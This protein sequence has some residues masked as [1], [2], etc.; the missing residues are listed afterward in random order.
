MRRSMAA[1]AT[2][3]AV[4]A[5]LAG[6]C[7]GSSG[8]TT[9]GPAGPVSS[10][11]RASSSVAFSLLPVFGAEPV[12]MPTSIGV[13]AWT[14]Y[15]FP[16]GHAL[17]RVMTTQH[18]AVASISPTSDEQSVFGWSADAVAWDGVEAGSFGIDDLARAGDDVVLY[19]RDVAVRYAW[20]GSGWD[21]S[22]ELEV[23][24]PVL[25]LAFGT[26][27]AVAT[28]SSADGVR[29]AHSS[30]G[31]TFEEVDGP[32]GRDVKGDH[33]GWSYQGW[34][35]RG[36]QVLATP[37]GFVAMTATDRMDWGHNSLCEP[38]TW[39]SPDGTSW[40]LRTP[41][42]RFGAGVVVD[43]V[44]EREG[45]FV[46]VGHVGDTYDGGAWSA[47]TSGDA[48]TWEPI[49]ADLT[50]IQA[51]SVSSGPLGW[52]ITGASWDGEGV[53]DLMWTSPDGLTWDGPHVLP[54]GFAS[55]WL[56]PELT[57]GTDAVFGLGARDLMPV[58]ARVVG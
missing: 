26:A 43:R 14:Q 36:A 25:S 13:L 31:V 2:V 52:I 20:N 48:I 5:G 18:G 34:G 41:E 1:V 4:S 22:A 19:G 37:S 44:A 8:P 11:S 17:W 51:L 57:I 35:P 47:W 50:G 24:G 29:F 33:C 21:R 7:T 40:T 28:Y 3:A 9:Y 12:W 38:L 30:D 54:E 23:P 49:Q 58:V 56:G 16:E 45:R 15:A 53:Q 46:A 42:S 39:T 10:S 27:D 55:G 32:A 6:G